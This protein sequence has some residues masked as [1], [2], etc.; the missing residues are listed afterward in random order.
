MAKGTTFGAIHSDTDLQLIQQRVDVSPALPKTKYIDIPGADGSKDMTEALGVGVKYSDREITWTFA[1]YPGADW[2]TK[3]RQ[4][5]GALNGLACH[6][7]LD[8]DPDYYYDGRLTVESYASDKLIK[9]ITVKAVCRPY[10]RKQ[11]DTTVSRTD[12]GTSYKTLT[13]TNDRMPVIPAITVG[14]ATTLSWGGNT[15]TINAGTHKLPDI[16]LVNGSNTLKAKVD[17]GT[18]TISVTYREG[19]L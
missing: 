4:V 5:S 9:T 12:L 13:L 3:Q 18:G 16:C 15:Y 2:Y 1:L 11:A 7:T 17:S 19:A 8:D 6:I 10:K 14:Q